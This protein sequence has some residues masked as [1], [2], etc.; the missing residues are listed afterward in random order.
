MLHLVFTLSDRTLFHRLDKDNDVVIFFEN[1]ILH[2]LKKS[3]FEE[4][5]LA[6]RQC[7]VLEDGLI[8]RGISDDEL[9]DGVMRISYAQFVTMTINNTPIQTWY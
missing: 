2:L 6:L 7:Y 1:A 5:I 8:C 4:A 3:Y 9:I